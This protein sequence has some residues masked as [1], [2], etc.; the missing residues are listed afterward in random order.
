MP[1]RHSVWVSRAHARVARPGSLHSSPGSVS[2]GGGLVRPPH[3]V[4][5]SRAFAPP[6]RSVRMRLS[7]FD[8]RKFCVTPAAAHT[9]HTQPHTLTHSV[10]SSTHD[11]F[12]LRNT[13]NAGNSGVVDVVLPRGRPSSLPPTRQH[14]HQ[15]PERRC[16]LARHARALGRL[17]SSAH[18]GVRARS[19]PHTSHPTC[20]SVVRNS[21]IFSRLSP[22][23]S[24]ACRARARGKPIAISCCTVSLATGCD[25]SRSSSSAP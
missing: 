13:C 17:G 9:K 7:L 11:P 20:Q 14:P 23:I 16:P 5:V 10:S 24:C 1:A 8:F 4:C 25:T 12:P 22:N 19:P 2:R 21:R 18:S 6:P 3:C 15:P